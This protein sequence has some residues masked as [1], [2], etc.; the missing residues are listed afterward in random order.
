MIDDFC[1]LRQETIEKL[2]VERFRKGSN[3]Q[4][5]HVLTYLELSL[6]PGKSSTKAYDDWLFEVTTD[7]TDFGD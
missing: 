5:A 7:Y 2:L 6:D 3:S 1:R 4:K